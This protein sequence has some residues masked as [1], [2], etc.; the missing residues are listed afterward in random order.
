MIIKKKEA[1]RVLKKFK[2]PLKGKKERIAVLYY[3]NVRILSTSVPKGRND[4][5]CS[6]KFRKQLHLC[7]KQLREA[8]KCPFRREELIAKLHEKNYITLRS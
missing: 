8:V 4:M 5:R 2:M 1:L 3:R 6:D 7:P